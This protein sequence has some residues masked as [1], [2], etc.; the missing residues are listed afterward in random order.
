MDL[1]T[2][3]LEVI[4]MLLKTKEEAILKKVKFFLEEGGKN[5][6]FSLTDEHYGALDER[7]KR[8]LAG[9]N[10]SYTLEE[11]KENME[12]TVRDVQTDY[13]RRGAD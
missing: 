3:K 5:D 9:K 2:T 8:H 4:E 1:K 7:R 10:K 11:L 12:K 13:K 6:D